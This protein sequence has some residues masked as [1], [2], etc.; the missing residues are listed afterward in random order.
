VSSGQFWFGRMS[1]A[2]AAAR[3]RYRTPTGVKTMKSRGNPYA[4]LDLVQPLI[5]YS[6]TIQGRLEPSLAHLVKIRA[7]QINGCG[8]CLNMHTQEA[9]KDGET[10][11]RIFLLDA[12]RE[13]PLYNERERAALG[14]TEAL[15]RLS[16]T[17]APD[18]AYAAVEAQFTETERVNLTLLIGAI[19]SF[20]MLG[21]GFRVRHPVSTSAKA[22]A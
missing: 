18:E 16:A 3:P 17:Q 6:T 9:R 2:A 15:V 20:N 19:M 5:D 1:Q 7:S 8:V 14:W 12:W 13:S 22:A 21:V 10:Q 11:E 4:S